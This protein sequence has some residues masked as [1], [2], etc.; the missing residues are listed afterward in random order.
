MTRN[1]MGGRLAVAAAAALLL[2]GA[3]TRA[4]AQGIEPDPRWQSWLGCWEPVDSSTAVMRINVRTPVVC[5][6]PA[7]GKSAVDIAM[8]AE[9]KIVERE[10][11]DASG[12]QRQSTREGCRGWESAEWAPD[13]KRVY[14]RSEYTC[15]GG[16]KRGS[17]G[18]IAISPSGEWL[19]I[20]GVNAGGNR[21]V[22]VLRYR[23]ARYAQSLPEEIASALKGRTMSAGAARIAAGAPLEIADL[24]E[25]S[26]RLDPSVMEA[27]LIER[28]EGFA[29]DANRLVQLEKAGIPDR[30]ID[31]MVALSYPKVFAFNAA[32]GE[33]ELRAEEGLQRAPS[34]YGT[35][36]QVAYI[37][38]D[39]FYYSGYGWNRY[40]RYG[41][42]PYGYG[43]GYGWYP[44]NRPVVIV[45][46]GSPGDVAARGGRV[47]AGRGYTRG[48]SGSGD[49]GTATRR[50]GSGSGSGSSSSVGS[51]GGSS[52]GRATGSSTGSSG[53]GRTAKPRD[54]K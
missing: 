16:L 21:G 33:A 39:P 50:G 28:G 40:S 51:S 15:D 26:R 27:W 5:V 20:H 17:S 31:V 32:S 47:V 1:D 13:G 53:S 4:P 2:L 22:R 54:P 41:Y 44:G 35:P 24:L 46:R 30:V 12:E 6:T 42:S 48:G 52:G 9:G 49:G 7:P 29:V 10:R 8:V 45:V 38:W 3:A 34:A 37:D 25:A 43:Y 19:A 36:G 18:L 11:V 14:L 23:E